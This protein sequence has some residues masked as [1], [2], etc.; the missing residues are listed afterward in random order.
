MLNN[1]VRT[2]TQLVSRNS[3]TILTSFGVAGVVSTAILAAKATPKALIDMET[4]DSQYRQV[5]GDEDFQNLDPK[6]LF[7]HRTKAM[8][9][10]Y[11]PAVTVGAAT[12]ACILGAHNIGSRKNAA[13]ASAYTLANKAFTDYRHQ[14]VEMIGER[15]AQEI[16]DQVVNNQIGTL[17]TPTILI[18]DGNVLCF[19]VLTGRYFESS[20]ERIYRAENELNASMIHGQTNDVQLNDFYTQVGLQPTLMGE[21]MGW[22]VDAL[23]RINVSS[24]LTDDNKPALAI[25]Y[26]IPPFP[27]PW[28]IARD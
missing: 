10:N 3:T 18:G 11:I 21:E 14:V 23:I 24:H 5:W 22:N 15:K 12:I 6:W 13:L 19:E 25:S 26:E 7:W 20:A 2:A 4:A 8:Y 17:Q 1:I 16:H 28:K 27:K 9:K